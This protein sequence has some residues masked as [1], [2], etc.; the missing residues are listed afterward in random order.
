MDFSQ[1]GIWLAGAVVVIG[2]IQWLKALVPLKLP[3]WLWAFVM[4]LVSIGVGF[5][6]KGTAPVFD[7]LGVWAI[8]QLGYEAILKGILAAIAKKTDPTCVDPPKEG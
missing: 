1:I 7:G 2:L 8:S 4:A 3:G 6:M 5:S